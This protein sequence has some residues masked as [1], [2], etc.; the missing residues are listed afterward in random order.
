MVPL[1]LQLIACGARTPVTAAPAPP[2]AAHMKEVLDAAE[3][4]RLAV[5][6]GD[7]RAARMRLGWLADHAI[8]TAPPPPEL[9]PFADQVRAAAATGSD[10]A[11]L[12]EVGL[13]TARMGAACGSCHQVAATGPLFP[14][15]DL[16]AGGEIDAH[17]ARHQWAVDSMWEGLLAPN[18]HR[19]RSGAYAFMESPLGGEPVPG[20][21]QSWMQRVHALGESGLD[22]VAPE[23][24]ATLLGELLATCALCHQASGAGPG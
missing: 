13:A 17:M 11:T 9:A 14:S 16:P 3:A 5:I 7:G 20:G 6:E 8:T 10:A 15:Q 21:A 24:R 4:A 18:E 22:A 23:Q 12:L 1:L 2:D 19:W